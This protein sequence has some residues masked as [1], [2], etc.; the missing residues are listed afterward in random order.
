MTKKE[1]AI[2]RLALC[3]GAAEGEWRNAAQAFFAAMRKQGVSADT[4]ITRLGSP[5]RIWAV[6]PFG[7]HKGARLSEIPHDYLRWL[8][9]SADNL[10]PAFRREIEEFL[11]DVE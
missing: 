9:S 1:E 8:L 6:M 7:K 5:P 2:I 10:T 3:P 4:F 11:K